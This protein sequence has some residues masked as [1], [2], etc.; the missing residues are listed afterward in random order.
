MRSPFPSRSQYPAHSS[1]PLPA[2][3]HASVGVLH[4][5]SSHTTS[6]VPSLLP[7]VAKGLLLWAM[8]APLCSLS[9]AADLPEHK[10]RRRGRSS[11]ITL[12]EF[13]FAYPISIT[14]ESQEKAHNVPPKHQLLYVVIYEGKITAARST[15]QPKSMQKW[16]SLLLSE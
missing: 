15:A 11:R 3:P 16:A 10:F 4:F 2:F 14:E 9:A 6:M 5:I 8:Q 7:W 13:S 12:A 1:G